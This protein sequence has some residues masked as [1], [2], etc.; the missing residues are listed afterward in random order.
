VISEGRLPAQIPYG[1][2]DELGLLTRSFNQMV[3]N[4]R[5]IQA[6][7]VKSEKL[8]SLGRMAEG[9]AHE[10]RNPMNSMNVTLAC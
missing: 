7:L 3:R 10:I 6:K 5:R 4:L 1:S 2:R 8:V 9:V